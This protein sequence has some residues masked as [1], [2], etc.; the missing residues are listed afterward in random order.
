MNLLA[1]SDNELA[2]SVLKETGNIVTGAY[3][4]ALSDFTQVNMQPSVPYLSIDMAG[5]ILTAGLIELSQVTD[6]AIIINTKMNPSH[7]SHSI[8]GHF[9]FIPDPDSFPK[10]FQA[11][12]IN[13]YE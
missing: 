6:Y 8:E 5:A 9:L 2:I 11:L 3:L 4:S 10:L 7:L 13:G 12:G 1:S